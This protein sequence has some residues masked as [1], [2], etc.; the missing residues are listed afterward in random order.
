M[1]VLGRF[2]SEE[3]KTVLFFSFADIR[4]RNAIEI[5]I[6]IRVVTGARIK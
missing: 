1:F 2:R 4:I 3:G 6:D 5:G